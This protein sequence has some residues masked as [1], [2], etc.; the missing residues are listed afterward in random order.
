[1]GKKHCRNKRNFAERYTVARIE[2]DEQKRRKVCGNRLCYKAEVT[3]CQRF[4]VVLFHKV[5]VPDYFAII[6]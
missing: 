3:G 5:Q 1:M 4:S 2:C 6:L